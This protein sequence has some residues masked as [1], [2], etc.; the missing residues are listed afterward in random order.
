VL[1]EATPTSNDAPAKVAKPLRVIHFSRIDLMPTEQ[2]IY[3]A[4]AELETQ[5]LYGP[6][7]D[8]KGTRFPSTID[9]K[10]PLD[11]YSIRLTVQDLK[12][13]Q[14]LPDDQFELKLPKGVQVQKLE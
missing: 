3:N 4:D 14:P 13:N 2:D 8:F 1:T 9:I 10:R 7:Q 6:Y 12:V 5:V 11:E